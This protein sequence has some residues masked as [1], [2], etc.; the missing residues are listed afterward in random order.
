MTFELER[1]GGRGARLS[2][3]QTVFRHN[4]PLGPNPDRFCVD[5]CT[6]D[7]DLPFYWTDAEVAGNPKLRRTFRDSPSRNPPSAAAGTTRWRAIVSACTVTK[8][9]VTVFGS[10]AWGF[11]MDP[12]GTVRQIGPRNAVGEELVGHLRLLR[13]GVGTSGKAFSEQGWT[14]REAPP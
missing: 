13:K 3:V 2:W 1:N 11:N 4:Q 10:K 7:D 8:K 9:R 14:F 12:S 6:P 5:G